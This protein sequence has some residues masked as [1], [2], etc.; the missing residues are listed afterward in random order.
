[1]SIPVLLLVLLLVLVGDV[2]EANV[3]PFRRRLLHSSMVNSY[4]AANASDKVD[5]R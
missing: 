1:M 3:A 4:D 5:G 2:A